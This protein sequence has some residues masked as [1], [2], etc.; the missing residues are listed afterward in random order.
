MIFRIQKGVIKVLIKHVAIRNA[1]MKKTAR[2]KGL[3]CAYEMQVTLSCTPDPLWR[4]FFQTEWRKEFLFRK[5]SIKLADNEIFLLLAK[6]DDIQGFIDVVKQIIEKAN[7]RYALQRSKREKGHRKLYDFENLSEIKR[8][9]IHNS[10]QD[11]DQHS[12]QA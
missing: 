11:A 9:R 12:L 4:Q 2:E 1:N 10:A 3:A 6:G 5:R 7:Q 8:Y